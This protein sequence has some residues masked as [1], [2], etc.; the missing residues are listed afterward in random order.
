MLHVSATSGQ[1][2]TVEALLDRGRGR[3]QEGHP[4]TPGGEP[5][6]EESFANER[7][8]CQERMERRFLKDN[9]EMERQRTIRD[10]MIKR[11]IARWLQQ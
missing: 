7:N 10:I 8:D 4:Q 3:G 1:L 2:E 5:E 9:I 6:R 11:D